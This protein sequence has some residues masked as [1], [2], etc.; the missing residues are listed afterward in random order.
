MMERFC[1]LNLKQLRHFAVLASLLVAILFVFQNCA[2]P[3]S[4]E[5]QLASVAA[6]A[7]FAF[8]TQVDTVA[9]LSCGYM[10]NYDT[11]AFF[12][13]RAGAFD[14]GSGLRLRE[15]FITATGGLTPARRME[16]LQ[17]SAANKDLFF[18]LGI[19]Y[20]D[21]PDDLFAFNNFNGVGYAFDNF[22]L[23]LTSSAVAGT[24]PQ[25]I[26]ST[27]RFNRFQNQNLAASLDFLPN[28]FT[29]ILRVQMQDRNVLLA[30]YYSRQSFGVA[31]DGDQRVGRGHFLSFSTPAHITS[32]GVG[33]STLLTNV[34]ERDLRDVTVS[35][36]SWTCPT[37][38]RYVVVR[39]DELGFCLA[40]QPPYADHGNPNE[41]AE[42]RKILPA[43]DW[44][45]DTQS[46]CIVARKA[47]NC[48]GGNLT[49]QIRYPNAGSGTCD[50]AANSC[51]HYLSICKRN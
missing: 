42:L 15:P 4:N 39:K 8:D 18:Q 44:A 22:P 9:H 10:T 34:D 30:Q 13:F 49:G 37:D 1:S 38:L 48:Y 46:R 51:P 11:S 50:P 25:Q 16:V 19:R 3:L 43:S 31:K 7:P 40:A 36:G 26:G 29:Q 21:N 47:G 24:L 28:D 2:Q 5:D 20:A 17:S 45:I 33:V 12:T 14:D 41:I 6:A 27:Q 35:T 23:G 32:L